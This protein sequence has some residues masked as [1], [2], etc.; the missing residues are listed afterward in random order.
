[1]LTPSYWRAKPVMAVAAMGLV[2]M[3]P[4]TEV[5]PV[6]VMPVLVSRQKSAAVPRLMTARTGGVELI[7]AALLSSRRFRT[8]CG[9][10]L[11]TPARTVAPPVTE[12]SA[13]EQ[14]DQPRQYP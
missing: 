11:L 6:L 9:P 10:T 3:F 7:E 1:M 4:S 14:F 5:A 2:P 13:C 8:C 12:P